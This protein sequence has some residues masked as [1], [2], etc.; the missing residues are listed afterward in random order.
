M[1][2]V[3]LHAVPEEEQRSPA[4]QYHSFSRNLSLALGG[5]RHTGT[6]GDGHPFDLQIRRLPPGA[7]VCPSHLHLAQWE[8]FLV[9]SGHGTVRAGS[10]RHAIHPGDVFIHPPGEAHQ[11]TNTGDTDLEV[12]IVADNPVLDACY[13]PDSDK[14][15]LRPPMKI[16]RMQEVDYFDGEET[17]PTGHAPAAAGKIKPAPLPPPST[18]FVQRK[19]NLAEVPWE[20]WQSPKG[21]FR[22]A[23][24]QVSAALGAQPDKPTGRGG[25]PFDL[26]HGK[27][28]PGARACPCHSHALQWECYFFLA[29]TGE[30]RIDDTRFPIG[31][32]DL[33]LAAP[34]TAHTFANNGPKELFYLL[35]ADNPPA[36]YWHYPDSQKWGLRAPRR[37]FRPMP[38]DYFE[39]EE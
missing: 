7:A 25:H 11:L 21:S 37:F 13:Y 27:V 24:Q 26:E 12:L 23:G 16:F 36:D 1:S 2:H 20:S 28:P 5:V 34:G 35:V 8:L 19:V 6:W 10:E 14:W 32:G 31:A 33:V 29:G 38:I 39:G 22:S 15:A 9:R 3:H 18:P 30:F 17:P 4:G